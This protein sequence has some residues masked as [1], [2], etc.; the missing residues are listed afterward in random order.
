MTLLCYNRLRI[1]EERMKTVRRVVAKIAKEELSIST[2]AAQLSDS[3]DF[4]SIAVWQLE[5]ALV[6]AYIMGYKD[7]EAELEHD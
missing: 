3:K 2:L 7:K 5:K 6:K 4:H 1:E